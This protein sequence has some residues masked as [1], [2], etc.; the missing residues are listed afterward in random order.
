M[1]IKFR[2]LT[3]R[4]NL[5]SKIIADAT[6]WARSLIQTEEQSVVNLNEHSR[7]KLQIVFNR[8][9]I[10]PCD[11]KYTVPIWTETETE[12]TTHIPQVTQLLYLLVKVRGPPGGQ[13]ELL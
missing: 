5:G 4:K 3:L 7:I 12:Q 13:D 6:S 10:S 11:G 2:N 8:N 9:D 1:K